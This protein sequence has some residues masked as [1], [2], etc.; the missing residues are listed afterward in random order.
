MTVPPRAPLDRA[1]LLAWLATRSIENPGDTPP[2]VV[3]LCLSAFAA[4][5]LTGDALSEAWQ[6]YL[7]ADR[8]QRYADDGFLTAGTA[9]EARHRAEAALR[10][11]VHGSVAPLAPRCHVA[12]AAEPMSRSSRLGWTLPGGCPRPARRQSSARPGSCRPR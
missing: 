8:E 10:L 7:W 4:E 9:D 5:N 12:P 6:E 3:A 2:A 11:L 1:L